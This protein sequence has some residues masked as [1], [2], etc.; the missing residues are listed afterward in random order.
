MIDAHDFKLVHQSDTLKIR[1]LQVVVKISESKHSYRTRLY[2]RTFS[3]MAN[4]CFSG[5]L[6]NFI[7]SVLPPTEEDSRLGFHDND[8]IEIIRIN[9]NILI[10]EIY[11][12]TC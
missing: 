5:P 1:F 8:A 2:I 10:K 9:L 3:L 6:T 4:I 12:K 7:L 11:C